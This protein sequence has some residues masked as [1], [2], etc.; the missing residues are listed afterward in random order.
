MH[1]QPS[2]QASFDFQ[3]QSLNATLARE[4]KKLKETNRPI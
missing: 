1:R 4:R 3:N 2:A